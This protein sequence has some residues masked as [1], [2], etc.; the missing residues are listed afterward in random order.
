LNPTQAHETV[1][2]AHL[3]NAL[4]AL[5]MDAIQR[6]NS[7]HPGMPMGMA[8][9][10]TVLFTRFLRFDAAA[11][12]WPDRDRFVLSAGHGSMLLYAL[13]HLTGHAHMGV[14]EL[15]QFR[16]LGS[17][18]AGHP[19][20]PHTPGVETTTGPLGQGI[21]N[22]VGMALAE[23]MLAA[24]FGADLVD[25]TTYVIAGDGCLMEGISHEAASLAAHLGLG[26]LTVLWDDNGISIDGPTSLTVSE[27]TRARF[28]AYGWHV[29]AVDGHDPEAI[30]DAIAAAN[31]DPRPSLLACK[32]VI[33]YGS[34]AK[35][36][37]S[38]AHGAPLGDAEIERTRRRLEWPFGPFEIPVGVRDAWNDAGQRGHAARVTWEARLDEATAEVREA[39]DRALDNELSDAAHE[40]LAQLKATVSGEHQ[41]VASRKTSG[42]VLA[43]L[44][45][46]VP[47]LVG[48][49][50]DLTGSNCTRSA[51][52]PVAA[53]DYSGGYVHYGVREH[54]MA[55]A[56]NGM[57]LH[58][59]FIP[60]GGTFLV[61]ADYCRPS[62][63]LAA[64]MGLRVVFVMTHDSIGLGED[65]PTHQPVEHLASLRAIPNLAV[66][67]PA[68][69]VETV[70]CWAAALSREDGPSLIALS[71]QNLPLLRPDQ[72]ADG[73]ACAKGAYVL[74]DADG[75]RDVTILSTGSEVSLAME[76]RARLAAE[77]IQ[78][79]VVSMPCWR[80]FEQQPRAHRRAVLGSAP[81]IAV[82]AASRF[83]WTR[84]VEDEEDVVGMT[85]FGASGP[86]AEL[87][88]HF[89]ITPEAVCEA[90][91]RLTTT[92]E[93]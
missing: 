88:T 26:R 40:R 78:A 33:G 54:A 63:R 55:A 51:M 60:Y 2:H 19:E 17:V 6:A 5:S 77:G 48:G 70:E 30:A 22:A 29:T 74:A 83:G 73:N 4:R 34:P 72:G 92:E 59:G 79:A 47:E 85:T 42:R 23:R 43:A 28:T 44:T 20:Y 87:Y 21:A 25:H 9:V 41:A 80:L 86:A 66:F 1:P 45:E 75:P 82:E 69:A 12:D 89:G 68:D 50:A 84:Y 71:R 31:A 52:A 46:I 10:A 57:A 67:R 16:Q 27:D 90:A 8:D 65:G 76:A 13:Q 35:A 56:M 58:G 18:T 61:F 39:W 3:A 38:A 15:K 37:T 36:G 14:D 81:R 91:R 49:S 62:I 11:P 24:R 7:G 53:S 93:V 64:M 32:T